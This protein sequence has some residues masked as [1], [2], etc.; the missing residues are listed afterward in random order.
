MFLL[1]KRVVSLVLSPKAI[2]VIALGESENAFP[3][4]VL[5]NGVDVSLVHVVVDD[6]LLLNEIEDHLLDLLVGGKGRILLESLGH[7]LKGHLSYM[8]IR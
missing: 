2:V 4:V 6:H 8:V 5:D 7:F 1:Q 3:V